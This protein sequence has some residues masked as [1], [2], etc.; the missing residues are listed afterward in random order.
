MKTVSIFGTCLFFSS[1]ILALPVFAQPTPRAPVWK[2][3]DPC[4]WAQQPSLPTP[5]SNPPNN[6]GGN[7]N[8][9]GSSGAP[10]PAPPAP[11]PGD[12]CTCDLNGS[13]ETCKDPVAPSCKLN[14]YKIKTKQCKVFKNGVN[15]NSN[16][17][18]DHTTAECKPV[19]TESLEFW[20]KCTLSNAGDGGSCDF[21]HH[22]HHY[23]TD[24]S[25]HMC[26]FYGEDNKPKPL[27][28]RGPGGAA[29]V[30]VEV[31]K[32]VCTYLP[33]DAGKNGTWLDKQCEITN[34]RCSGNCYLKELA[35]DPA[36][37]GVCKKNQTIK[38]TGN[39]VD[40]AESIRR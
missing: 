30:P 12:V 33:G 36:R 39:C 26:W 7:G 14:G 38:E 18:D 19:E 27:C 25:C 23:N 35:P 10:T 9:N 28:T 2:G 40:S 5:P 24:T 6:G 16:Y 20:G 37:P 11:C 29:N 21:E 32:D 3:L 17:P 1:A 13:P 8:G 31:P 22:P 4:Y 34:N 15:T